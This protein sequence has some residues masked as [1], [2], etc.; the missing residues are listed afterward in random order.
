MGFERAVIA[1]EQDHI[2]DLEYNL[3]TTIE[4][5]LTPQSLSKEHNAFRGVKDDFML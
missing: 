5:E 1:S 4:R 2:V 3:L